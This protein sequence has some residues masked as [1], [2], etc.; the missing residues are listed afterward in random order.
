MIVRAGSGFH[1]QGLTTAACTWLTACFGVTCAVGDWT[2]VV[3]GV[4][5]AFVVLVA[6]G[7]IEKMLRHRL[8]DADEPHDG[9]NSPTDF[10]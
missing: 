8:H 10:S 6:G 4:A 9:K 1:V 7:P 3:M 5:L 2:I